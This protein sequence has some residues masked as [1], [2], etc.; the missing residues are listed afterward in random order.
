LDGICT[1]ITNTV[2]AGAEVQ[3]NLNRRMVLEKLLF[4]VVG[5]RR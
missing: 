4:G 1:A 3:R 5:E 2:N